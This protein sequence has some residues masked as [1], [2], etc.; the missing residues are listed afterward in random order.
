MSVSGG[1]LI[2][3]RLGAAMTAFATVRVAAIQA[4]PAI[5]DAE[6]SVDKAIGLLDDAARQGVQ[7]AVLPECFVSVYPSNA[8]A[9][10][11]TSFGGWAELWERMW[12]ES[13]DAGGPL[14]RRLAEA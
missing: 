11:A 9:R 4:T 14:V 3:D 8:W 5:L 13:V 12:A 10:G 6:A 7:L 1:P 2:R